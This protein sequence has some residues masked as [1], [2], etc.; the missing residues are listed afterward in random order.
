MEINDARELRTALLTGSHRGTWMWWAPGDCTRYRVVYVNPAA[1]DSVDVAV[2]RLLVIVVGSNTLAIPY[3][4]G[5]PWTAE[6]FLATFGE[7]YVGWWA[8]IRPVLAV[9]GWTAGGVTYDSRDA[10]AMGRLLAEVK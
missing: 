3:R 8:G 7:K 1:Y 2:S 9:F 4:H 5:N 6:S 10:D